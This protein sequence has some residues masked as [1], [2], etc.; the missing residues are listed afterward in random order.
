MSFMVYSIGK[1]SAVYATKESR[2]I[3]V[4]HQL[5]RERG[6]KY[7]VE[8]TKTECGCRFIPMTEDVYRSLK[9]YRYPPQ[10]AENRENQV[11]KYT[12]YGTNYYTICP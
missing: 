11:E 12:I 9:K 5:V 7:Y 4:Y 6:G 8:K 1:G 2:K 10:E 3:R